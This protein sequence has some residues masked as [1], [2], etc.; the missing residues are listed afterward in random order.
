[1]TP[2]R[3][4][5]LGTSRRDLRLAA[6]GAIREIAN[7]HETGNEGLLE[8]TMVALMEASIARVRKDADDAVREAGDALEDA[9]RQ[10]ERLEK[11][12]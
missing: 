10:I 6:H 1:M 8:A 7:R 9:Q 5:V 3:V 4:E 2:I 12:Q 11:K